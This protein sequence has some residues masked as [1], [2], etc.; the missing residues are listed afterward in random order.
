MTILLK[1]D[2]IRFVLNMFKGMK[3]NGG[4]V[5]DPEAGSK[6]AD[7]TD[8]S[9]QINR[10]GKPDEAE[11]RDGSGKVNEAEDRNDSDKENG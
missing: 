3:K 1:M 2:E 8:R 6:K 7:K 5:E 4:T 9:E 10:T 11:D